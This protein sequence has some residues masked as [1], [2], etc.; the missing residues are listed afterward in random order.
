MNVVVVRGVLSRAPVARILPSGDR[1]GAFEVTVPRR[2]TPAETVPVVWFG[3]P[4]HALALAAGSEVVVLGRVR[5][6]FYR[7]PRGTAS[8]TEVVA[9]RVQHASRTVQVAGLLD[10]AVAVLTEPTE[11]AGLGRVETGRAR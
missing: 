5:R 6:R 9:E 11:A 4:D 3:V 8:R 2:S 1:L 10:V 7:T